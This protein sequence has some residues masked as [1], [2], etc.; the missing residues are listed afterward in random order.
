MQ[1][2]FRF[3]FSLITLLIL[4]IMS[5]LLV[6]TA[7]AK[8]VTVTISNWLEVQKEERLHLFFSRS[9]EQEPRIYS[10]WPTK[11]IEPLFSQDWAG[12]TKGQI[13]IFDASTT[14]FPFDSLD[15]LPTGEWYVQAIF[16][17]DFLDSRIN[18]PLNIY[19][20]VVKHITNASSDMSLA[21]SLNRRLTKGTLPDGDNFLTFVKMPSQILSEFWGTEMYLRSGVILP[22]SY[23]DNPPRTYPVIFNHWWLS[24]KIW[25]NSRFAW[26]RGT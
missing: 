2:S 4:F 26:E 18:S 15:D 3:K 23:Y 8:S 12:L 1:I 19:S 16:D 9:I 24:H 7:S 25:Q 20:D 14:G 21:L 6:K 13:I 11:N 22:N 5:Q 17:S 10:A